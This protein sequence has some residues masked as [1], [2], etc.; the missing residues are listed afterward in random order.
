MVDGPDTDVTALLR[1]AQAG[2]REAAARLLPMVYEE[3][4]QLAGRG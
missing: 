2:D 3:L 1:A 4:R